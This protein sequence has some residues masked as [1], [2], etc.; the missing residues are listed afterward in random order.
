MITADL[1]K[2]GQLRSGAKVRFEPVSYAQA[3]ALEAQQLAS[4]EQLRDV[5][6]ARTDESTPPSPIVKRRTLAADDLGN[7]FGGGH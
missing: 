4:I 5:A 2:L 1:W 6:L 3:R 7:V